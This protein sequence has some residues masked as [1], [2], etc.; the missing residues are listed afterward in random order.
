MTSFRL[1]KKIPPCKVTKRLLESLEKYIL[2]KGKEI[3]DKVGTP[4]RRKFEITVTDNLGNESFG[5]TQK[6]NDRF[7]P[8]TT[9]VEIDFDANW[10]KDDLHLNISFS[11]KRYRES[12]IAIRT[13][14]NS[15]RELAVGIH[16]SLDKVIQTN[17]T[18]NWFFNPP[19]WLS[20][21]IFMVSILFLW[22]GLLS[23]GRPDYG[24]TYLTERSLILGTIGGVYLYFGPKVYPYITFDS[25]KAELQSISTAVLIALLVSLVSVAVFPGLVKIL[26]GH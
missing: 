15:A 8:L 16:N 25:P 5:S 2:D 22:I 19:G 14:G 21:T 23:F 12:T 18:M 4:W 13:K 10:E 17:N 9:E 26:L 11:N 1:E 20:F 24:I 3:S 7:Y 6:L